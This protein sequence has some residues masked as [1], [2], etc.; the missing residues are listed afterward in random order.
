MINHWLD[1]FDQAYKAI[2]PYKET[3]PEKYEILYKNILIE[4]QFPRLVLCT[5]YA[6]T[7][8]DTQ[9]KALRKAFYNDFNSL[10]NTHL[11]EGQLA[12]VVFA[13]WDL[14]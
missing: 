8:N 2:E 13:D 10:Q 1:L 3:D 5:T 11:K 9:L 14:D 12:D 6:S 4:S 7:Y